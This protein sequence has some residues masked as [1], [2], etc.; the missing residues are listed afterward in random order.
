[1]PSRCRIYCEGVPHMRAS[2]LKPF[3]E[4]FHNR[5]PEKENE[6]L[7]TSEL[8]W[9][10]SGYV[11]RVSFRL[12]AENH[13]W[14]KYHARLIDPSGNERW[15]VGSIMAISEPCHYGGRRWYFLCP[16]TGRRCSTVYFVH[17]EFVS[18]RASGLHY[19]SQSQRETDRLRTKLRKIEAKLVDGKYRPKGMHDETYS[20]I[21]GEL[22]EVDTAY[23]AR[24]LVRL[25]RYAK[26]HTASLGEI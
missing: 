26:R 11:L 14:L 22:E 16:R 19:Q 1:M 15:R 4:T 25:S 18:Y 10:V 3:L 23:S 12:S 2:D 7:H 9:K 20:R 5:P 17:G 8:S 13:G 24:L 21:V 6:T